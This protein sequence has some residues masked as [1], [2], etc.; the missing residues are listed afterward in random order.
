MKKSFLLLLLTSVFL[1][2]LRSENITVTYQFEKPVCITAEDGFVDI[3]VSGCY[4]DGE[5][6]EPLLPYFGLQLLLP[7]GAEIAN[8]SVLNSSFYEKREG[9]AV[10]PASRQ[11]PLSGGAVNDYKPEPD[12]LI[13]GSNSAFPGSIVEHIA[14]GFLSG[15][16]IGSFSICPVVYYPAAGEI[17]SLK[18]ITLLIETVSTPA[19]VKAQE[20]LH[21]SPLTAERVSKIVENSEKIASYSFPETKDTEADLLLIT[22]SSYVG[23]FDDF[24]AYKTSAGFIVETVTTEYIYSQYSGQD[25]QERIRNCIIDYY[26][27]YGIQFVILGGDADAGNSSQNIIPHRGF[28]ALDDSDI[29]SDM[30][31]CCLDGNWNNDGDSKW[32]EPGE[33]DLYAEVGIGRICVDSEQEILNF[34]NKLIM[35]QDSPVIQDIEKALMIGEELNNNPQTWGGDYKDEI[36]EGTSIHGFYTEGIP[37]NFSIS[38]LYDREGGWSKNHV[39]QQF[40]NTGVNLLNHLGHSSPDYNMK[41]YTS[42]VTSSNFQ[43]NGITRGFVIGYSQGC[44]NGSFDNRDWNYSYGSDCFAEKITTITTAEVA[45]VANSRYGWYAPGNTNSSSQF[46]DRQFFDAIF[47][48]DITLIGFVNSDSKED[49]A[50]NFASSEYIRWTVYELNLFGDPS[51]DIWTGIPTDFVAQYP[52]SIPI[53][54]LQV[55]FSTAVPFARIGLLQDGILIGRAVADQTGNA[56]VE[57]FSPVVGDDPIDV[58]IIAHNKNRHSGTILVISDQPFVMYDSYQVNDNSGNGNGEVDFG[59]A[60][61]LGL[62]V[63]NVGD[64]PASG[65]SVKLVSDDPFVTITDDAETYGDFTP[66]QVK[67]LE[68]AFAF[69]VAL[70]IPNAHIIMFTVEA[71]GDSTWTSTFTITGCAPDLSLAA[72]LINDETGNNNGRLDPGETADIVIPVKNKGMS[73]APAGTC[74]LEIQ[75]GFLTASVT[76]VSLESIPA[77]ET[78]NA[79]FTVTADPGTPVGSMA[80]FE[81][82]AISGN[83]QASDEYIVKIGII[84]EDWESGN[85]NQ[86]QWQSGGHAP[87]TVTQSSPYEGAY[88][89]QS[90]AILDQQLSILTL[91]YKAMYDDSVSFYVKVSSEDGYD[92]LI[93]Y[94]DNQI[95]GQWSGNQAW[96]KV[97]FPVSQGNHNFRFIYDKDTY[98]SS[99]S[100]CAWIDF[101]EL[102]TP[103]ETASNAGPDDVSCGE[104]PFSCSGSA[105]YYNTVAWSTSGSGTFDNPGL[106]SPVYT[107]HQDDV[108]NGSV[109]LIL[110]VTGPDG[111]KSDQ[112]T[113]S[114]VLPATVN[115]PGTGSVCEGAFYSTADVVAEYYTGLLWTTSGDGSF[116]DP[117]QLHTGY[118][119]GQNDI[120]AGSLVI[121][122][123]LESESPCGS[124]AADILLSIYPAPVVELGADTS[125]CLEHTLIL[126]AM[127][128]GVAYLWSTGETTQTIVASSGGTEQTVVYWVEVTNIA[129]CMSTDEI[130][131]TFQ[132]CAGLQEINMNDLF[133][134][135]PN[136][137][138]DLFFVQGNT[139]IQEGISFTLIDQTRRIILEK[140]LESLRRNEMVKFNA[141]GLPAGVYILN[142]KSKSAT[143]AM[144]LLV[145]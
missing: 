28:F 78:R 120:I 75:S 83:Y 63:K 76:A 70:D 97:T 49:L 31:Y 9:I 21:S 128:Q 60:I 39:F 17:Q 52:A 18:E 14:T 142:Y 29:P 35:Y 69:D 62:G 10:R 2:S 102:P 26:Q 1:F 45:S 34:T 73:D 108:Q 104:S 40:N 84:V 47:G 56:T 126:D 12:Q 95:M 106:L 81:V 90:G 103:L 134:V 119:P 50:S 93:F 68:D 64:Q 23:S 99:G 143:G 22:K 33:Y 65:V 67:Y 53:G 98:V 85:F 36:A 55:N 51:M 118:H 87:W 110:T 15:Y 133:A 74:S 30:Y 3:T 112:M 48:E 131:L 77:G 132:D 13:Y 100:D 6:G 144:K 123:S 16:S 96:Q 38:R 19:A 7:Q 117:A 136:P 11:F 86:F 137:A 105:T 127:N 115:A 94:I 25:N 113:L 109:N 140:H 54:S 4:P 121:T 44:Y 20:M 139:D 92:F 101:I 88:C 42:D 130:S 24:I 8:V 135:Y 82:E 122:L 145:K 41:M 125:L 5:E 116:D 79:I 91:P 107:P 138:E 59:E 46:C 66:G 114:L 80:E 71:T 37:F 72:C 141:A 124:V 58:S 43:N 129:G 32:G 61:L 27:N 89:A 111:T 57:M